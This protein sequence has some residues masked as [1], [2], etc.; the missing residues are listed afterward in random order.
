MKLPLLLL[1]AMMVGC[2]K[3]ADRKR[4]GLIIWPTEVYGV[5]T[6]IGLIIWPIEVYGVETRMVVSIP[7]P[8]NYEIGISSQ[9][10]WVRKQL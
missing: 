6:R 4:I 7:E 3:E 2:A 9:Q 10:V 1:A 8:G 5:E